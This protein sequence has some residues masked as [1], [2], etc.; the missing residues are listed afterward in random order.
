[1]SN[2]NT[3]IMNVLL[4]ASL[5][6]LTNNAYSAIY[7]WTDAQGNV[8]FGDKIPGNQQADKLDVLAS[9]NESRIVCL[10]AQNT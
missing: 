6:L 8:H 3:N 7:K 10:E 5:L 4:I 2:I 9:Y 1:M